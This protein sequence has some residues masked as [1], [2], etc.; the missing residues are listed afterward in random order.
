M[1]NAIFLLMI[2]SFVC[3]KA[4]CDGDSR[5][6]FMSIPRSRLNLLYVNKISYWKSIR[7][8]DLEMKLLMPYKFVYKRILELFFIGTRSTAFFKSNPKSVE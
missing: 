5:Y 2:P 4:M 6:K 7:Q 3:D 8:N 1:K